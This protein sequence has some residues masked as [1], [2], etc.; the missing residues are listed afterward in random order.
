MHYIWHSCFMHNIQTSTLMDHRKTAPTRTITE[1]AKACAKWTRETSFL[2]SFLLKKTLYLP[3]K[4]L[5]IVCFVQIK[6]VSPV[7]WLAEWRYW[8]VQRNFIK[9][10]GCLT[11]IYRESWENVV[12]QR[13]F[14]FPRSKVSGKNYL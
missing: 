6:W 7:I 8:N 5:F 1:Q 12:S 3:E 2:P 14:R 11:E 9:I 4:F 10:P 13:R